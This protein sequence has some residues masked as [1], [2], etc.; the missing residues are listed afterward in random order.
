MKFN[1]V[2]NDLLAK[3]GITQRELA[4]KAGMNEASISRYMDGE[5]SPSLKNL[6]K[7]A[8]VFGLEVALVSKK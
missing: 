4:Q 6:Q 7:I 2:L 5:R 8:D 3:R 1:E